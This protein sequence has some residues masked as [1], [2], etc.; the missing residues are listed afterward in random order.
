MSYCS[1]VATI[2][3]FDS[4]LPHMKF[5]KLETDAQYGDIFEDYILCDDGNYTVAETLSDLFKGFKCGDYVKIAPISL[6]RVFESDR[7]DIKLDGFCMCEDTKTFYPLT[8]FKNNN[9][10]EL[11]E[12]IPDYSN[13]KTKTKY[14]YIR[15]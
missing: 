11:G 10:N 6:V 4:I 15:K 3:A 2:N 5:I 8:G 1:V 9:E 14:Y 7:N 13:P 12:E